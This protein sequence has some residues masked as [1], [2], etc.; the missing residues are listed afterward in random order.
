MTNEGLYTKI[1]YRSNVFYN[2]GLRKAR[3]RDLSGAAAC[4]RESLS[5]NKK[6]IN[7][8]NLLGL[9][10]FE[11]GDITKALAQWII[12][13]NTDSSKDNMALQYIEK[14]QS[15]QSRLDTINQTI[16]KYNQALQY[17]Y[18]GSFDLAII[19]LK[20]VLSINERLLPA[21]QLLALVYMETEEYEKCRRTVIKGLR[22]DKNNT[23]LLSY[24]DEVDSILLEIDSQSQ[25]G[26]KKNVT[27]PGAEVLSY[28][29]GMD[30][31]IQPVHEKE[32][33]GFS[34]IINILIGI[35]VGVAV[36][37]FLILPARIEQKTIEF[38]ARYIEVSDKL[39]EEQAQHSQDLMALDEVTK[40]RD[41]LKDSLSKALGTNGNL[42]PEDYLIQAASQ[43]I[44][45][46]GNS[47]TVMT[48]LDNITEESMADKSNDFK[49]LYDLLLGNA[50]PEVT[51]TYV[52]A[53][54]NAMKS[55][56]Y[57]EAITQYEKAYALNP[58]NSDILMNLAHAYRQ[59][60]NV[61]K[62]NELYRKIS[63]DFPETQ[64]AQDALEYITEDE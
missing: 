27:R 13:R 38:D 16:K 58:E 42:R 1:V 14:V 61:E 41:K 46:A 51:D 26:K 31:I 57:E 35:V 60:G 6:N 44:S 21:Y 48:T 29:S 33:S 18:Q 54:K 7:A 55:N 11:M 64:N 53:A 62:A 17:S 2:E 25:D 4:L 49:S 37:Y 22:I 3:V 39:S 36:C 63:T 45:G 52:T 56:D 10:Y 5:L 50:S 59:N 12:S 30:T 15:N 34:S 24:L 20:K 32:R 28:E 23:R 40:D 8:R 9:V 47:E 43:Y 19:Q